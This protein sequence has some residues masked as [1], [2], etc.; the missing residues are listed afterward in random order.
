VFKTLTYVSSFSKTDFLLKEYELI[1][2]SY[3][4]PHARSRK[5]TNPKNVAT[6]KIVEAEF[7][8]FVSNRKPVEFK[9]PSF[10]EKAAEPVKKEEFAS[11]ETES[12]T[13]RRRTMYFKPK[14]NVEEY[15]S[16]EEDVP[17][18]TTDN[19]GWQVVERKIRVKRDKVQD[20]LDNDDGNVD[21]ED[22]TAWNDQPE[23]H[24]TYWDDRR[25]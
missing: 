23:E 7:P 18:P 14:A 11:H 22:D 2:M 9:G 17:I 20:A 10:L 1:K 6:P 5:D 12:A 8:P 25:H 24:E 4:H 19:D 3:V 13:L 15:S 16:E 21:E